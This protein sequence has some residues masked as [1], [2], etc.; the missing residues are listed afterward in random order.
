M[1]QDVDGPRSP[2]TKSWS[3]G[4]GCEKRFFAAH[5]DHVALRVEKKIGELPERGCSQPGSPSS[6]IDADELGLSLRESSARRRPRGPT[7]GAAPRLGHLALSGLMTT[8]MGK[9]SRRR[10][11][12]IDRG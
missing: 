3:L 6:E 2:P 9:W 12:G 7:A 4:L 1:G 10:R 8:S 11:S 5:A